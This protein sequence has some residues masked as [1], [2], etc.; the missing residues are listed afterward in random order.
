MGFMYSTRYLPLLGLLFSLSL[1]FFLSILSY[2]GSSFLLEYSLFDVSSCIFTFSLQVD[3][4]SVSFGAV[5]CIISCCVFSFACAYMSGDPYFM[6][7]INILLGFVVSMLVLVYS[8]SLFSMLLGW[9]GLGITSFALII[10]YQS[11]ESFS[12]G[13]HTLMINRVG[14]SIIVSSMFLFLGSGLFGYTILSPIECV[15]GWLVSVACLT[16]SAHYPFSSWLPAAMAAPTPVSAL[17]HSSTLVTAGIF[18]MVRIWGTLQ[19]PPMV[20]EMLLLCG[21]LTCFLGGTAAVFEN[22]VKKLVALSTLSQLGVMGFCLGLG[23][24][25]L[26]LFHLYTHALFKSLLFLIVGVFLMNSFGVQDLRLLGGMSSKAPVVMVPFLVSSLCLAGAPFMSGFYSKHL[27]LEGAAQS[28]ISAFSLLVFFVAVGLTGVYVSRLLL[29]FV[30]G[31]PTIPLSCSSQSW[32]I[33]MPLLILSVFSVLAGLGL[34]ST[35]NYFVEVA[36]IPSYFSLLAST[37]I[38]LFLLVWSISSVKTWGIRTAWVLGTMFFVAPT[39]IR[40]PMLM[41]GVSKG[42]GVLESGWLEPAFLSR[43]VLRSYYNYLSNMMSWPRESDSLYRSLLSLLFI[44]MFAYL[45][46]V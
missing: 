14:D 40:S 30:G 39:V 27:I 5:I 28:G 19:L 10:Y 41:S 32:L 2:D 15:L 1:C 34:T 20:G 18:V 37:S 26:S 9:D 22:D 12:A 42:L 17:V 23:L 4:V 44:S 6:R 3:W 46:I 25:Y 38:I 11:S 36:F 35:T 7:F 8:A 24:P 43:E 21:A 45:V 13:F 33:L 16:K 31:S 29:I